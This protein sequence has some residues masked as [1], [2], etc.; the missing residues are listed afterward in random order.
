MICRKKKCA[1]VVAINFLLSLF[2][3][4]IVADVRGCSKNCENPR[5]PPTEEAF[6]AMGHHERTMNQSEMDMKLETIANRRGESLEWPKKDN[7]RRSAP[8]I[9][10][11]LADDL[12]YGDLSVP[13]F[14]GTPIFMT[15]NG[16]YN[17]TPS[18]NISTDYVNERDMMPSAVC[19]HGEVLTPNLERMAKKGVKTTNFH[20]ASPVC[21]P[22][23]VAIMTGLYPWRLG[24]LNA[25]ELGKDMKQRNGYLPQV[26]TGPEI[27]REHGYYTAHSG[28][29]H[30]GG[31]RE[32][33]RVDRAHHDKCVRPG[34]NQ[35]GFQD[36]IS[37][38]D[39]PESPRYTFLQRNAKTPLHSYGYRHCLKNDVPMP[40]P[41]K[42]QILSDKEASD[43]IDMITHITEQDRDQPWYVQV[44]FN[45][46]HGPWELL[47]EGE[48]VYTEHYG[49]TPDF[50][51]DK[52]CG[53]IPL[54]NT[55]GWMYK[56]MVTAMDKSIGLLL[57]AVES[58][59]IEKDTLILF[60]SDNGPE[61]NAGHAGPYREFKR[62]LLEGGVRV[63][64]IW[65]WTD[66]LAADT[67]ID[68]WGSTVDIFPTFLEASGIPKPENVNWDGI[69]L[70]AALN[71]TAIREGEP[72]VTTQGAQNSTASGSSDQG[73][74]EGIEEANSTSHGP[75]IDAVHTET[76][77]KHENTGHH[78]GISTDGHSYNKRLH[79]WHKV[80]EPVASNQDRCQSSGWY[81]N[82]KITTTSHHGR[83]DR[84]FDHR[85]DPTEQLNLFNKTTEIN[86]ST[87][88]GILRTKFK[89]AISMEAYKTYCATNKMGHITIAACTAARHRHAVNR[90][91]NIWSELTKFVTKGNTPMV[92]YEKERYDKATCKV[93][94]VSDLPAISY[95]EESLLDD[96]TI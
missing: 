92:T 82:L 44:W 24:A 54:R 27:F 56:S 8:N 85:I 75:F 90:A 37:A 42:K 57:D 7:K 65:Q 51:Q 1:A 31:M 45:A 33:Q 28:K 63:P 93:P 35:H 39:G 91:M 5:R 78:W 70:W 62:S 50:W 53:G 79:L 4:V 87:P 64:A 52:V 80:T 41:T 43:A 86:F 40:I 94:K 74:Y 96:S 83:L 46:P 60:T 12:G 66:T 69:S 67:S 81:D 68:T 9:L 77:A 32:E 49:V 34:P 72:Q 38:L 13:P 47:E 88:S 2:M 23:R 76:A 15:K 10:L 58:L 17:V 14:T 3:V 61:F 11:I 16:T 6:F 25:F 20:S 71:G 29:W 18:H 21:S 19:N 26:P 59:G 73:E 22:S 48:E 84:M 95:Y 89:Q 36:A 55:R 30:M